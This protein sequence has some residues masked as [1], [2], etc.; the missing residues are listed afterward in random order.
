MN[1]EFLLVGRIVRP[2]GVRGAVKVLPETDDPNRF[3]TLKEAFVEDGTG[4]HAVTVES[5][6]LLSGGVIVFLAGVD[7]PEKAE[8][9]RGAGL[10]VDRAHAV[11]LPEY[12]Y[13]IADLL[14]CEA[15]DTDGNRLERSPMCSLR[16]QTTCT[17][18]MRAGY[19]FRR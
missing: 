5:A 6:Q 19:L 9:L 12:S 10:L 8:R 16:A 1:N 7:T 3:L 15:M 13:F 2:H 11:R 17:K 18:S 14:G 4:R